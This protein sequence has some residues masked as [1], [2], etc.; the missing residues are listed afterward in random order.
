M[1]SG[2][3]ILP[4]KLYKFPHLFRQRHVTAAGQIKGVRSLFS[5]LGG[6]C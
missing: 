6:F 5:N 3:S 1:L 2:V 4:S